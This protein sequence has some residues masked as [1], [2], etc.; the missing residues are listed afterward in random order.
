MYWFDGHCDVLWKM[1]EEPNR[2][3]FYDQKSLLDVDYIGLRLAHALVQN[4]AIFV[5]PKVLVGQKLQ[6]ALQQ[7]DLFYEK[8]IQNCS[9][10]VPITRKKDL[11]QLLHIGDSHPIGAFLSLEG[12]EALQGE[13]ANLRL[14]H[15][16]G[17]RSMGLTWN[18]ANEVADGIQE[19]R[20]GGLT[21]F[22]REV[23][24]EMERLKMIVDVSHL[25]KR[26]FW[27]VMEYDHLSVLAS[28]SNVKALCPHVRNL[29]N[30]QIR[31]LIQRDGRIGIVFYPYFVYQPASL[32]SI[33][34]VIKHIEFIC[35]MGGE[36]QIVFGSDFDGIEEKVIG[37]ETIKE[38]PRFLEV[39]LKYYSEE[40]VE[41]W[42]WGNNYQFFLK[43][44]PNKN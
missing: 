17:V 4:F 33:E 34:H 13:L 3:H 32:A 31:A 37:L 7:I 5:P 44:L 24:T 19:A 38:V 15:R 27:E 40:L 11:N 41:K 9:Y 10:M 29:D 28:H 25:S 20:D 30:D 16:L 21:K 6:V 39:L 22:G 26:G 36:D 12:A 35:E 18:Y 8:I 23:M 42:A 2:Y 14:F 43:A 1:W